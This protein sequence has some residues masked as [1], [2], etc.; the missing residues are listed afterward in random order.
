MFHTVGCVIGTLGA[1]QSGACHVPVYAFDPS[2]MLELMETERATLAAAVPT[3][4]IALLEC[5]DL[6]SRDLSSL[7]TVL[8]GGMTVPADLVRRIEDTLGVRLSIQYGTTECSPL[9]SQ[10][11]LDDSFAD[12]TETLGR[13]VPQTEVKIT[14]PVTGEVVP[15]GT[16]GELCV[17]GYSVMTGYFEMPEQTAAAIDNDGWYHTGDLAAMDDRGFLRI[18]GRLN[19]M[20]IRGGENI[21]PREIEDLLFGH[22]KVAEA[23]VVGVA[24]ATWGE[25]VA[26]FVRAAPGEC[27]TSSEL[28]A[29]CRGH[30]APHKTPRY[31]EFVDAFPLT[32]SGKIQKFVLRER[33]AAQNPGRVP[34]RR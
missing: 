5:P 18:E 3:M 34:A 20:I 29:Y 9:V 24:D 14:D 19:D 8:S 21:Y 13:P 10:V 28:A 4:L 30:L 15:C 11:R 22:P 12:K 7:R 1:L 2:L 25:Q 17:R 6:A 23:A 33:F 27:P 16:V 32:A 31:W 26:A